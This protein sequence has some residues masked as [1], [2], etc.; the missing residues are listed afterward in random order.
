[1][2]EDLTYPRRLFSRTSK[3]TRP[4]GLRGERANYCSN[5]SWLMAAERSHA[6]LGSSR[7]FFP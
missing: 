7:P 5:N 3:L 2:C 6:S 4:P 1:V